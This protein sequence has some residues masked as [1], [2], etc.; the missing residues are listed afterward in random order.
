MD[1]YLNAMDSLGSKILDFIDPNGDFT[2]Y[3]KVRFMKILRKSMDRI[4]CTS[5]WMVG[6]P[7][8]YAFANIRFHLKDT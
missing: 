6:L 5:I 1:A 3:T 2:G 4:S 7:L 8:G